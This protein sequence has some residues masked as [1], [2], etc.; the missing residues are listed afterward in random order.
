MYT[1]VQKAHFSSTWRISVAHGRIHMIVHVTRLNVI[2]ILCNTILPSRGII[3]ISGF[4]RRA[5]VTTSIGSSLPYD[6]SVKCS[7]DR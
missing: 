7:R 5:S 2:Q 3:C 4:R 6:N 1:N